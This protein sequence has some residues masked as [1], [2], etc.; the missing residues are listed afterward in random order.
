MRGCAPPH[1]PHHRHG[2][3]GGGDI[4]N[5][6][7]ARRRCARSVGEGVLRG[8][9]GAGRGRS[10][11][12]TPS[13]SS[14]RAVTSRCP[15]TSRSRPRRRRGHGV[16]IRIYRNEDPPTG[17]VVYF[18]GGGWVIGS[19]GIMDNVARDLARIRCGGDLGR[20]S[21]GAGEPLPRRSRRLRDGHPVGDRQRATLR[22]VT[23]SKVAS[24]ARAPAATSAA[25]LALRFR[26]TGDVRAGRPGADLP[27]TVGIAHVPRRARSSTGSSSPSRR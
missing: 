10:R 9:P 11:R 27:A 7:G 21:A 1:R 3:G 8:Q 23:E 18:H 24:P 6:A 12:S 2:Q 16:P 17:L 15:A 13:C 20:V 22:R 25:A 26:D 4:R 19:I 14:W 5:R